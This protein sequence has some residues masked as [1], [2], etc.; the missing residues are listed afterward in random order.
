MSPPILLYDGVCR[1]CNGFVQ[2]VLRHDNDAVFR[3]ASLQSPLAARILARHAADASDLDTVCVVL[4]PNSE[5][6]DSTVSGHELLLTRSDAVL[7]VLRTFGGFWRASAAA[8]RWIP[9]VFRDG[10]YRLVARH[11]YRIFGRHETCPLPDAQ[12]RN[13]FLDQDSDL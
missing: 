4:N 12:V 13:R 1:L 2:F 9:R 6:P 11:R 3:F 5:D 7:F 8:I 10:V